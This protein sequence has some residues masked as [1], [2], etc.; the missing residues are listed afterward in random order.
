MTMDI[1]LL[2]I[3]CPRKMRQFEII[4]LTV[5]V[6]QKKHKKCLKSAV[7]WVVLDIPKKMIKFVSE[8]HSIVALLQDW[9]GHLPRKESIHNK[10]NFT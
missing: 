4:F 1:C 9:T 5:L 8:K 7:T 2:G 6:S 10:S 3:G